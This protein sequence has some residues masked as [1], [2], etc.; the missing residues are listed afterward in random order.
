MS[1]Q[2]E[3]KDSVHTGIDY[4]SEK[5]HKGVERATA[6]ARDVKE[7]VDHY[8]DVGKTRAV[9][10]SN[11][12]GS[13]V[14]EPEFVRNSQGQ[15]YRKGIFEKSWEFLNDVRSCNCSHLLDVCI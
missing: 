13:V 9:E 5:V 2:K 14:L 7:K 10:V 6:V 8:A 4:A 11:E 12:L 1:S 15:V 3:W